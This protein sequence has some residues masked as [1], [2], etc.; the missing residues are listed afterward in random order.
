V[1]TI[2][3]ASFGLGKNPRKDTAALA[4]VIAKVRARHFK[5]PVSGTSTDSTSKQQQFGQYQRLIPKQ[6]QRQCLSLCCMLLHCY[7]YRTC[8]A[9]QLPLLLSTLP[10]VAVLIA[11]RTYV[12]NATLVAHQC[13]TS[14]CADVVSGTLTRSA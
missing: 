2:K 11:V 3:D 13:S 14:Q 8:S 5:E 12:H 1:T 4:A 7:C 9:V 6:K 10:T